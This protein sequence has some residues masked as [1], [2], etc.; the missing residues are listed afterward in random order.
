VAVK[1]SPVR[2]KKINCKNNPS[3]LAAPRAAQVQY[4]E[5]LIFSPRGFSGTPTVPS[6]SIKEL[7]IWGANL[8]EQ[9]SGAL[10][11]HPRLFVDGVV[12]TVE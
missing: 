5:T 9:A 11:K 10:K 3:Q 8:T 12:E 1:T 2:L 4:I 6:L 7:E